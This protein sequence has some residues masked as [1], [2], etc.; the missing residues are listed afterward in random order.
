LIV[1][2]LFLK[3][4]DVDSSDPNGVN[5]EVRLKSQVSSRMSGSPYRYRSPIK[6]G[7]TLR[8]TS[9]MTVG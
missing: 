8:P 9:R 3:M 4:D 2:V 6:T 1:P 5:G 7:T